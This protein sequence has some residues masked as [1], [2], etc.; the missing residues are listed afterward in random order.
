MNI[1][2]A[3][4]YYGSFLF[5]LLI[6]H[7][8]IENLELLETPYSHQYF[9]YKTPHSNSKN[10]VFMKYLPDSQSINT[11]WN[12][13]LTEREHS[14]L[15]ELLITNQYENTYII[16]ICGANTLQD[17]HIFVLKNQ[18]IQYLLNHKRAKIILQDSSL[19]C[20]I[21]NKILSNTSL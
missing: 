11:T 20:V 3:D 16:F 12:F 2:R 6:K 19:K 1:D 14:T 9:T 15:S 21:D 18:E 10:L 13:S 4:F 5:N 8:T 17:S 7:K